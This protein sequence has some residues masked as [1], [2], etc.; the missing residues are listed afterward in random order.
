MSQFTNR[1]DTETFQVFWAA[2]Q[3]GEFR[4]QSYCCN[5]RQDPPFHTGTRRAL[6]W[7]TPATVS[8]RFIGVAVAALMAW[9]GWRWCVP[10][11]WRH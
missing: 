8:S 9:S 1:M 7:R 11:F 2:L 3:R 4:S 5:N 6:A 10:T